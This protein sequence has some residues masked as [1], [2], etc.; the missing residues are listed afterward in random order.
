MI[1]RYNQLSSLDTPVLTLCNPGSVYRNGVLSNMVGVLTDTEAEEIVF[2]FNATSEL[3]FRVNKVIREDPEEN[4]YVQRMYQAVQNRRLVFVEDIGYFVI[5]NIDDG[6]DGVK[7]YKDVKAKSIDAE[8]SQKVI[9]YIEDGIY[10]FMTDTTNQNRGIFEIIVESLPLWTIG[11]VDETVATKWRTFTD[12]DTS[13]N[14]LSF[15]LQNCQDAYECIF[16]FDPIHRTI[17]VYSQDNY[18][19]RTDVH[20]TKHDLVNTLDITENADDLYTAI[21]VMGDGD[22]TISAIN[23]LGSNVLYNFDYYIPWMPEELGKKVSAWQ[24]TVEAEKSNYYTQNLGYF[25]QFEAVSTYQLQIDQIDTQIKMYQRCRDNIVA[26]SDTT[27]VGGYNEEI[28]A[29]GGEEIV[30]YEQIEDTLAYIDELIAGCERDKAN[31]QIYL[32][33]ANTKM[34]E[35]QTAIKEIQARVAIKQH[36]TEEEY[37]TLCLYIYEGNYTDEYVILTDSMTFEEKFEQMKILYDRAEAQLAKASSPTQEFNIDVENFLFS[38]EFEQWS[39][40]LE[41][42]CLINVE[43]DI[44]DIAELFLSSMTVNYD[45]HKLSMT[46]GNR[47]NKFDPKS[48]FDDVL[49]NITKTANTLTYIKDILYPI[50]NGEFDSLKEALATSRSLTMGQALSS[51]NEEV[52]IDGSGYT[53]RKK[54]SDGTYDDHQIKITGK[55]IVFT[56]DSWDTCKVAIGSLVLGDGVS[57]YGINAETILGDM[58]IGGGLKIFDNNGN[59][60]LS[61]IDGIKARVTNSEGDITSLTQTIDGFTF[62]VSDNSGDSAKLTLKSG[63]ATL[64]STTITMAGLVTF[65]DLSTAGSTT[66]SGSNITTG[67]IDANKVTVQNLSASNITSGTLNASNVT[68]TN[69][70]VDAAS[71]TSGTIA[72]ARI[73]NLSADKITSGT[74]SGSMIDASSLT[75]TEGATIAGWNIDNNSIYSHSGSWGSGTFMCTGSSYSYSIGG[76]SSTTGWVFGAGGKF[77]VTKGGSVWCSDLHATGGSIGGWYMSSDYIRSSSG[78]YGT[79]KWGDGAVYTATGYLF[80][81]LRAG[82]LYYGL[83]SSNSYSAV[84]TTFHSSAL[85]STYVDT[86]GGA[87]EV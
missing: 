28:K 19:R 18:V 12:L 69:L 5:S 64:A 3:N 33:D 7:Q 68:I 57:A 9:P 20:I 55:N 34:E 53:G 60:L 42:G 74:I 41:T 4:A 50:K 54:L 30:I 44:D 32:D 11:E 59:E 62:E 40:Q 15:L 70:K 65:T 2:N 14:C 24:D 78:T 58:I 47:F 46:F 73:P 48:L 76:S 6:F 84:H 17:S 61:V 36:F 63:N 81:I 21:S 51:V 37:T 85:I 25:R 39:E 8:L 1:V 66:I 13:L 23:P 79:Y 77:G 82:G 45:D 72:T 26:E 27:F 16:I 80:T 38:R 86:S 71:I 87:I 56:N 35:Y 31:V 43:L 22:V 67:T 49:G 75:I 29:N 83:A 52:V 10:P